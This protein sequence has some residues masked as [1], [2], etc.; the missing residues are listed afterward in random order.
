MAISLQV[1]QT[2]KIS[3][4]TGNTD[5]Y[6]YTASN[7]NATVDSSGTVTGSVIGQV[8]VTVFDT[9]TSTTSANF[10]FDITASA[11]SSTSNQSGF[12]VVVSALSSAKFAPSPRRLVLNW[13]GFDTTTPYR[14]LY[15]PQGLAIVGTN[16]VSNPARG[17][18]YDKLTLAANGTNVDAFVAGTNPTPSN[19]CAFSLLLWT[20]DTS[21]NTKA[22]YLVENAPD[23]HIDMPPPKIDCVR[24]GDGSITVTWANVD[25][26]SKYESTN[27]P[28]VFS[29]TPT[30]IVGCARVLVSG[31]Y[32]VVQKSIIGTDPSA[33]SCY[34]GTLTIPAGVVAAN[35]AA[36]AFQFG[37]QGLTTSDDTA[38]NNI[39]YTSD[40]V[41]FHCPTGF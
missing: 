3:P 40:A 15:A 25:L 2:A 31:A 36:E 30:T 1:G 37:I 35:Q 18:I 32:Q 34:S 33:P 4:P 39:D 24:N 8:V 41:T 22:F 26:W 38:A 28:G 13:S 9:T 14:G 16:S 10:L 20:T 23:L 5:A 11:S 21:N 17:N 6:T 29:G 19:P 7:T 12:T 27:T